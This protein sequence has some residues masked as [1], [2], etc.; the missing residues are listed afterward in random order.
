MC[1]NIN[2]L[3]PHNWVCIDVSNSNCLE[4][5]LISSA[6]PETTAVMKL[7]WKYASLPEISYTGK[8]ALCFVFVRVEI[9]SCHIAINR[10]WIQHF[11]FSFSWKRAIERQNKWAVRLPEWVIRFHS[12]LPLV[13]YSL[14][15]NSSE[16]F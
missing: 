7:L 16:H 11:L 15:K 10:D 2:D 12:K 1:R 5:I 8:S 14:K 6:C 3:L 9:E 4:H 13:N